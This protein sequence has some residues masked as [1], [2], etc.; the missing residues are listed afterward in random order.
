MIGVGFN[1]MQEAVPN[2][3]RL[4]LTDW[5]TSL[6]WNGRSRLERRWLAIRGFSHGDCILR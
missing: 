3:P 4:N 6:A 1:G 5:L 2:W